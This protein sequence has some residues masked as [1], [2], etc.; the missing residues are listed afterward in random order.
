[1]YVTVELRDWRLDA[2]LAQ[3]KP[4]QREPKRLPSRSVTS[5]VTRWEAIPAPTHRLTQ[6]VND[7]RQI[8]DRRFDLGMAHR[9][10]YVP[11]VRAPTEHVDARSV[12]QDVGAHTV[13][14]T[15][16]GLGG[17]LQSLTTSEIVAAL[18]WASALLLR[19]L[20]SGTEP[21]RRSLRYSTRA[22][23][24]S[25]SMGSSRSWPP[26]PRTRTV[27]L[28]KQTSQFAGYLASR[29]RRRPGPVRGALPGPLAASSMASWRRLTPTALPPRASGPIIRRSFVETRHVPLISWSQR[30]TSHLREVAHGQRTHGEV[31]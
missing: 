25:S 26:F 28:A 27:R 24:V 1:M 5:H 7:H 19:G 21:D 13:P 15:V 22:H 18:R 30:V 20:I 23:H 6:P 11:H 17:V 9:R 29:D 14:A 4:R 16:L 12:T 31:R 10:L 8:P 2:R 3:W